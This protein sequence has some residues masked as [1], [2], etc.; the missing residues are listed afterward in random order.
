MCPFLSPLTANRHGMES[1]SSSLSFS[2]LNSAHSQMKILQTKIHPT[3]KSP[4]AIPFS[5]T[6]VTPHA[7]SHLESNG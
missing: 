3:H 5:Q 2:F 4:S 1:Q 6:T 7:V